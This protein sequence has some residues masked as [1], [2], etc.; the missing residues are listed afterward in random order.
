MQKLVVFEPMFDLILRMVSLPFLYH[1]IVNSSCFEKMLKYCCYI[2]TFLRC[3]GNV[4]ELISTI[5]KNLLM[6]DID[7]SVS[8][9]DNFLFVNNNTV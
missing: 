8:A 5:F 7:T 4:F 6:Q 2:A 9:I 1:I 3:D